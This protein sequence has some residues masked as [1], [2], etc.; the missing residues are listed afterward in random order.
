MTDVIPLLQ[1]SVTQAEIDAVTA[2]LKSNWWGTGKVVEQFEHEMAERYGYRHCVAVNSATA[3]LHLSMIVLDIE[4]GDEVIVP[5]LT[6]VST[7]LA[8]LYVGAKVVLADIR[9]DT[10]CINWENA[11]SLITSRTKAI[12]PVDYAGY[13]A[14]PHLDYLFSEISMVQDAAHSCGSKGYGDLVCLSFHP[15][16][17]LA[18]GDGGAI[19][20][21]SDSYDDRL[22]SLRWCGIDRSTWERTK[23]RY[24]WDY[25]ITEIGYK[26]H[27]NDV[28]AAIGLAQL[29]RL[30][31]LNAKRRSIALRYIKELDGLVELPVDMPGH[32]WHLFSIR[33]EHRDRL[34][35]ALLAQGVSAGVHYKPLNHYPMF[36]GDTP[37]TEREW[38]RLVT[39]PVFYDMTDE[40]QEK[41]IR[42]VRENV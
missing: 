36:S 18:T 5:A 13:L 30:D 17:N 35:D 10:L 41:V 33:V 28:Q 23:K 9:A 38:Q 26:C 34:I 14:V 15:V 1:P 25:N 37:V 21:N 22:R 6:F 20:T 32:T 3:A 24:G 2:V 7:G 11:S 40:Q 29:H 31:D 19:L 42:I 4:P 12:I 27:W 39:L 16:K 8:P